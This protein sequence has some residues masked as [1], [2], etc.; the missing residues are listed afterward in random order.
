MTLQHTFQELIQSYDND[1]S[2]A[3]RLWKEIERQYNAASRHY[4]TLHHLEQMYAWLIPLKPHIVHWEPVVFA[5]FY[6]DLVYEASS[7]KNEENSAEIARQRLR[8]IGVPEQTISQTYE[9]ILATKKHAI[10]DNPDINYFTDADLGILGQDW[11]TYHHYLKSIRKEYAVYP[12]FLYN[13]GR[14][15]VLQHFLK[16]ERIFKTPY[17]SE[18]FENQARQ[19]LQQEL[20]DL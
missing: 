10:S 4:H 15:Q 2:S 17:F 9:L 6:H 7:G 16:M 18:R 5:V 8:D 20:N 13:I 19:N 14:K 1:A 11:P 3:D 12:D